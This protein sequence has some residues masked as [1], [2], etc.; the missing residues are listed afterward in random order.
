MVYL[1]AS[2]SLLARTCRLSFNLS[3]FEP[4]IQDLAQLIEGTRQQG[5]SINAGARWRR[6]GLSQDDAYQ[7]AAACCAIRMD[8]AETYGAGQLPVGRKIGFTNKSIWPEYNIYASNWGYMYANTVLSLRENPTFEFN[9]RAMSL[10]PRIEPEVVL[11]MA[12][13]PSASMSDTELLDCVSWFAH[14]FEVVQSI[15]RDWK[16]NSAETT[17]AGALHQVLLIG[18]TIRPAASASKEEFISALGDVKV[19]LYRNQELMDRGGAKNV[20]GNPLNALRHLCEILENQ[21]L[22]PR[23]LP[24]EIIT[25]GT[26]TKALPISVGDRWHTTLQQDGLQSVAHQGK[27]FESAGVEFKLREGSYPI[28]VEKSLAL[29]NE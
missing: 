12:S 10:Q 17:A 28:H 29:S 18:R 25:T 4:R 1:R 24:G 13:A 9:Q 2:K 3:N 8:Q 5:R 20:L 16:F 21:S 11:R 15:Y 14:G 19:D 7:V 27:G 22:H 26:M 23:I 6:Q